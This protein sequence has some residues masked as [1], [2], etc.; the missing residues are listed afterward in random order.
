[1]RVLSILIGG[2]FGRMDIVLLITGAFLF[3]S[4]VENLVKGVGTLVSVF[5]AFMA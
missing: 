5:W 1:L 3:L 4:V 2:Y